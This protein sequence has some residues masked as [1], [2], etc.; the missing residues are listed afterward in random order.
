M[1]CHFYNGVASSHTNRIKFGNI[2]SLVF[3]SRFLYL[4]DEKKAR[5]RLIDSKKK[6][7][8]MPRIAAEYHF[9]KGVIEWIVCG[10]CA[11]R[12][13]GCRIGY[14]PTRMSRDYFWWSISR[15]TNVEVS[16]LSPAS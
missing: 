16:A 6:S 13:S 10:K 11:L 12:E 4:E 3:L 8:I 14:E 7:S 5:T 1:H 2:L 9:L 15:D